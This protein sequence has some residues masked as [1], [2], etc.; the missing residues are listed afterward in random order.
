MKGVI[1]VRHLGELE[2]MTLSEA[3][4]GDD[5]EGT[6]TIEVSATLMARILAAGGLGVMPVGEKD[7]GNNG[8]QG[9][10]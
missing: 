4:A 9:I 2:Q 1:W 5:P 6:Y 8:D 7:D 10:D 3:I